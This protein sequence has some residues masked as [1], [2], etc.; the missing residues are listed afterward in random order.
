[1]DPAETFQTL[2][3]AITEGD[4]DT[5]KQCAHDLR[6][7]MAKGGFSPMQA[8]LEKYASQA[9]EAEIRLARSFQ[10]KE[11]SDGSDQ[12]QLH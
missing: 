1:M 7:W 10:P 2:L 5:I 12:D 4:G 8:W 9:S 3:E 6:E 11:E